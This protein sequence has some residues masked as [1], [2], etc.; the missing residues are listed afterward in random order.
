MENFI[1]YSGDREK[2][3][4]INPAAIR[5]VRAAIY[6][7]KSNRYMV[8]ITITDLERYVYLGAQGQSVQEILIGIGLLS[9]SDERPPLV[10]TGT[11]IGKTY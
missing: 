11:D 8:T 1:K 4:W 6:D 2:T 10:E 5:T 9:K 7:R 3:I